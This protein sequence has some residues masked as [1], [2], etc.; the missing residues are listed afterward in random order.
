MLTAREK[1]IANTK[2]E[3]LIRNALELNPGCRVERVDDIT[4]KINGFEIVC[5]NF[6]EN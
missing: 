4:V 5:E 2:I 1:F 3:R 6:S